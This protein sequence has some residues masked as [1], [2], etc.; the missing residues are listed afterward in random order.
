MIQ[1][2]KYLHLPS[3]ESTHTYASSQQ[4]LIEKGMLLQVTA[5][6]QTAGRGRYGR[7][8]LSPKE[9]GLALSFGF[10]ID[11]NREDC[12]NIPQVFALSITEILKKYDITPSL[13]WPNDLL[14]CKKKVGGILTTIHPSQ[15]DKN[16]YMVLSVGLNVRVSKEQLEALKRPATSLFDETCGVESIETIKREIRTQFIYDLNLFIREGFGPFIKPYQAQQA[17]LKGE[18]IGFQHNGQLLEETFYGISD[19]GALTLQLA[20]GTLKEFVTGELIL[21]E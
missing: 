18:K 5:T 11:S 10:Y 19:S 3:V 13:K 2:I 7:S 14:I 8:W 6:E 1:Q 16:L 12:G 9:Q 21:K 17:F 4:H 20:D 15:I